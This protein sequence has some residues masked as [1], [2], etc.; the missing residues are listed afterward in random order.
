MIHRV[1]GFDII[2]KVEIDVLLELSCFFDNPVDVGTMIS[3]SSAFSKSILNIWKFLVHIL[4][5]PSLKDFE[6]YLASMWNEQDSAVVWAFFGIALGLEW[7]LTYSSSVATAKFSKLTA[8]SFRILNS[9]AGIP[10]TP[11]ALFVV[12]LPNAHLTLHTRM[13]GSRWVTTPSWL[14]GPWS[15]VSYSSS[16]CSW[17]HKESDTTEQLNW[18]GLCVFLPLL[19]LFCLG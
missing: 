18:A 13:S 6:H 12:I 7:K 19:N 16:V 14:S 17:G 5:K 3:G 10:W 2:N 4:L 11:L 15:H 8:S 1:K 9:S